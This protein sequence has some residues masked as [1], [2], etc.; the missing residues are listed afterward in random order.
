MDTALQTILVQQA[1]Y[2]SARSRAALAAMVSDAFQAIETIITTTEIEDQA[3]LLSRFGIGVA[4]GTTSPYSP[5]IAAM[6]GEHDKSKADIIDLDEVARPYWEPN[7]SM[8]VYF[9]TMEALHDKGFSPTSHRNEI[10]NWI[11]EQGGAQKVANIRKGHIANAAAPGKVNSDKVARDLY[12]K[13]GPS[14]PLTIPESDL[15]FPADAE[16]FV[17]IFVERT[18]SGLRYRGLASPKATAAMTKLADANYAVMQEREKASAAHNQIID[19]KKRLR[20]QGKVNTAQSDSET[21][22]G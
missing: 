21:S 8:A 17:T 6:W 7:K 1:A 14:V 2:A 13:H 10:I 12:V 22:A 16:Q 20:E 9:H 19:L 3:L 18:N 11:V 15:S 5:W 4:T